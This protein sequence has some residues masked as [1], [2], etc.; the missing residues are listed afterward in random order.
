M[1]TWEN[2][3]AQ[4]AQ[5]QNERL[6]RIKPINR[7]HYTPEEFIEQIVRKPLGVEIDKQ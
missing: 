5:D 3:I 1:K 4:V 7:K 6:G 2:K